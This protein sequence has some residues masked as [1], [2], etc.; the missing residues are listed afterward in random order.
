V[1]VPYCAGDVHSGTNSSS[2][3]P[4][5]PQ[6]QVMT[7]FTNITVALEAMTEYFQDQ[8]ITEVVLMGVSAGG[9]GVLGNAHQV[10][11]A[12]PGVRFTAIDDSGP[13]FVNPGVLP[14]CLEQQWESI[15]NIPF[16]A[17]FADFTTGTY[18]SNLR[19]MYEYLNNKYTTARFGLISSYGDETIRGFYA[20]G[21]SDC[22]GFVLPSEAAYE[23]DLTDLRTDVFRSDL[24][25]WNVY[26][27]PGTFHTLLT[28]DSWLDGDVPG[29]S[30]RLGDWMNALINREG[31]DVF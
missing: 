3:V 29:T 13:V 21:D 19:S 4:G 18:G 1:Y 26:Y 20:F 17:D 10:A 2:D 8:G 25:S 28:R 22:A 16:P 12:F 14:T 15:F 23:A 31:T 9:F 24:T 27:A 7:G 11:N 30:M 6:D 5:G